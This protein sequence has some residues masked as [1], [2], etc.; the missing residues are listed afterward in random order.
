MSP[1]MLPHLDYGCHFMIICTPL[2]KLSVFPMYA[3]SAVPSKNVV[4]AINIRHN[5]DNRYFH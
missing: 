3:M 4:S 5:H 2:C 1:T